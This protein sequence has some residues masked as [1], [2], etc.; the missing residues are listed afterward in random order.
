MHFADGLLIAHE[1]F[2]PLNSET[3]MQRVFWCVYLEDLESKRTEFSTA[4]NIAFGIARNL[5][6]L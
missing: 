6:I 1:D 4:Q 3:G 2:V 5:D